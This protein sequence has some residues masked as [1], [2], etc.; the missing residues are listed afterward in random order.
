M[1]FTKRIIAAAFALTAFCG[2]SFAQDQKK[3]IEPSGT[4]MFAQRDTCNLYMDVY[5]P[6]PA[7]PSRQSFLYSEA[8]S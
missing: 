2:V 6:A 3:A 1:D 4:Y 8:V 7:Y 5:N